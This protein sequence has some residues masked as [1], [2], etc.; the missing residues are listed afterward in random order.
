MFI[1]E[2]FILLRW[3]I[4]PKLICRLNRISVKISDGFLAEIDKLIPKF[5]WKCKEL[6]IIKTIL[7]RKDKI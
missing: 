4:V 2:D 1:L 6:R 3:A 7:K 5:I